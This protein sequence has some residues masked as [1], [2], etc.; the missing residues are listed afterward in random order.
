MKDYTNAEYSKV[1]AEIDNYS[2]IIAETYD[3]LNKG[4]EDV[5]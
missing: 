5:D 1:M 3:E 2:K 4:N